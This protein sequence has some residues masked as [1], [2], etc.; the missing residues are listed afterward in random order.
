MERHHMLK[1]IGKIY[2]QIKTHL[3]SKQKR[4]IQIRTIETYGLNRVLLRSSI[5]QRLEVSYERLT[6]GINISF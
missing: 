5:V 4:K 6:S 1:I 2:L 3:R